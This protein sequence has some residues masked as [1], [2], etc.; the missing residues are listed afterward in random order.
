MTLV[1]STIPRP[2]R[3]QSAQ[4]TPPPPGQQAAPPG[5]SLDGL[6]AA[7]RAL[8]FEV[9][10][11]QFCPCGKP[12]SF[13]D[14]MMHP[15]DCPAATR[16]GRYV[17]QLI[18]QGK[19]KRQVVRAFLRQVANLN[20]RFPFDLS[21]SPRLGPAD[22]PIKVVVFSDFQCP[23]CRRAAPLLVKLPKKHSDVAVY[24]KFFPL[25]FHPAARPAALA[26]VAAARQGKFWPMHDALFARQDHLDDDA[27]EEAAKAVGLDMARFHRDLKSPEVA[28]IVEA[29]VAEGDKARVPGTPSVYINGLIVDDLANIDKVIDTERG[30][31]RAQP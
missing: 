29:D 25:P 13:L 9:A 30:G 14:S 27:I 8:F 21:H 22:A 26:A 3:C 1:A 23:F 12:R 16:L 18:A 19:K 15:K 17:V 5:V 10:R 20:A 11:S 7:G 2:A 28:K 4:G 24:F 31:M 6:D